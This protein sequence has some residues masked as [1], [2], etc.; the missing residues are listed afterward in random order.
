MIEVAIVDRSRVFT[1]AVGARLAV[2]PDLRIRCC[3][4]S[5][6]ALR[7]AV[8]ASPVDVV[9][10][11][12]VLFREVS[13]L[14]PRGVGRS[15]GAAAPEPVVVLVADLA[16][17]PLLCA[18][19]RRG[20]RGWVPR[21]GSVD[22]LLVAVREA[23]GGGT[24]VPPRLLT[25]VLGEITRASPVADPVRDLLGTLTPREREVLLCLTDG[26]SRAEIGAQLHLS[27]NTVRTHVQSILS[28]LGV[29]SS[30]AAVALCR[31]RNVQNRT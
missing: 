8:A 31:R 6:A 21:E 18:A 17:S 27:T 12:A 5:A 15:P 4:T 20:V 9:V 13:H 22:D 1:E 3:V 11:E 14:G 2:E 7:R 26:S 29:S 24:W 19:L 25:A 16:E 28:K 10:C 23:Y 30:V